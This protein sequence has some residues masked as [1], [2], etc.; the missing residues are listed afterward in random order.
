[1]AE[2][3]I[4]YE[5][6]LRVMICRLCNRGVPKNGTAWH[7]REHHKDVDRRA[8]KDIVK[9][10]NNFDLCKT[11]EIQ[12]PNTIIPRI[13]ELAVAQGVRCSYNGCN[14]AC[15]L[16]SGMPDHLTPCHGWKPSK[17]N[18]AKVYIF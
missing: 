2:Q 12:Y 11:E 6:Q 3:Y 8:R 9:Y 13:E 18:Y 10:C 15:L 4:K 1:M 16:P 5:A 17:G 14:Y 7:Y